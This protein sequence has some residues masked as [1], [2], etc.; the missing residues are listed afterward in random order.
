[1]KYLKV[2]V[3]FR[4]A[5]QPLTDDEKGRL[6]DAMLN[7]AATGEEP[8]SLSGNERF[9]WA[10]AKRDIDVAAERDETYKRNGMKGGRP[11][12]KQNQ[13]EPNHNL[14]DKT[15]HDMT[16][17]DMTLT[18]IAEDDAAKINEEQNRV[19]DAAEDAGFK[20]SNDVRASLIALYAD[21]GLDKMLAGFRSCVEHGVTNL[22]YLKAVLSGKPKKD[23]NPVKDF[24]Q[25][26]YSSEQDAAMERMM[27]WNEGDGA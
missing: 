22:A 2:W 5:L 26:D 17:H 25:R 14:Q 20:V 23:S 18:F 12:T 1:M 11:K 13:T 19:L 15:R 6:F 24:E 4:P 8:E 16:R 7:Y 9:L 3:D 10:V 21:N 27:A